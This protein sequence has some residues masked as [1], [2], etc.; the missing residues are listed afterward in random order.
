ME[1]RECAELQ[2]ILFQAVNDSEYLKDLN[3]ADLST[4][5]TGAAGTVSSCIAVAVMSANVANILSDGG[6]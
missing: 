1:P 4:V 3:A 5:L 2:A 6:R